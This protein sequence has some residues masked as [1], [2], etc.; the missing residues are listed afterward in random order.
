MASAKVVAETNAKK[1]EKDLHRAM[2][3]IEAFHQRDQSIKEYRDECQAA[4]LE[5]KQFQV[6]RDRA[7]AR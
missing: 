4:K 1:L 5:S 2:K 7:V 3:K 6:E